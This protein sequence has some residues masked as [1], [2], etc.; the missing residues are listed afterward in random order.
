METG[1]KVKSA[2]A[3]TAPAPVRQRRGQTDGVEW[4]SCVRRS[5]EKQSREVDCETLSPAPRGPAG[6]SVTAVLKVGS[7]E[8]KH[9]LPLQPVRMHILR[10]QP[11]PTASD[12]L[13]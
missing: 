6:C 4:P 7:P 9:G 5:G 1:K 8:Q 11:S 2:R 10:P 13:G 3:L 12:T